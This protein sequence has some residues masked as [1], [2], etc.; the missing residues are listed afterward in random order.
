MGFS[1]LFLGVCVS[2]WLCFLSPVSVSAQ[3]PAPPLHGEWPAGRQYTVRPGDTLLSVAL[4]MG[5][6]LEQVAC[7]L[8]PA[9]AW[10]QPLVIGDTLTVPDSPFICHTVQP[11]DSLAALAAVYGVAV[12][13]I[14]A[15]PWNRVVAG[16][17]HYPRLPV[18]RKSVV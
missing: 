17:L 16:S 2:L 7:L 11:G 8:S 13:D 9:F 12:A 1:A 3:E 5:L 15:D 10:D 4:E 6:D 18:D 14:V